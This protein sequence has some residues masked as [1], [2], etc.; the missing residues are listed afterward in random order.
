[1]TPVTSMRQ[2]AGLPPIDSL[3]VWPLLA[4]NTTTSPR[5]EVILGSATPYPGVVGGTT[6]VQGLI[7]NQGYKILINLVRYP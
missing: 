6:F 5:Q 2:A 3:N 4:G 7:N 1:M